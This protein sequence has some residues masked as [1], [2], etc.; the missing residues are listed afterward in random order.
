MVARLVAHADRTDIQAGER[1]H[2]F[3]SEHGVEHVH[4][5][6]EVGRDARVSYNLKHV[7]CAGDLFHYVMRSAL[8]AAQSTNDSEESY[9]ENYPVVGKMGGSTIIRASG[10]TVNNLPMRYLV[11]QHPL[12][13]AP[14]QPHMDSMACGLSGVHV[15]NGIHAAGGYHPIHMN[16]GN[17]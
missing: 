13:P 16:S 2:L 11:L 14:G 7:D 3:V 12:M 5:K 8:V 17:E 10:C 1:G 4:G 15:V 6:E 9:K